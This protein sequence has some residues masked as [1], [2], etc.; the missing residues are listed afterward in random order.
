MANNLI[1]KTRVM[2]L[3]QQGVNNWV[4]NYGLIFTTAFGAAL[5][6][7]PPVARAVGARGVAPAHF[8]VPAMAYFTII[9]FYDEL[10]KFLVRNGM[11]KSVK[12]KVKLTGW[13]AR[14]TF[15]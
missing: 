11:D 8:M 7:I 10:R 5:V 15:Y 9:L 2:N 14:N 1:T 12:G 13:F 6:Y 3:A 4:Q